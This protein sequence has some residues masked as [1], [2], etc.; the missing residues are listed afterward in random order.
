MDGVF[1]S[2]QMTTPNVRLVQTVQQVIQVVGIFLKPPRFFQDTGAN[3]LATTGLH[4][5][6]ACR[7][8]QC[9]VQDVHHSMNAVSFFPGRGQQ[10]I[11]FA[12]AHQLF[13]D[14]ISDFPLD[15]FLKSLGLE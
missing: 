5:P 14:S 13:T 8:I 3:T 4:D 15:I 9:P 1:L 7:I 10:S 12:G 2:P 11:G 6:E